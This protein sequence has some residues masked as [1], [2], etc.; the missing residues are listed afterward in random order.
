[1]QAHPVSNFLSHSAS[2]CDAVLR[3]RGQALADELGRIAR[4]VLNS[5]VGHYVPADQQGGAGGAAASAL[6]Q[7]VRFEH[8]L[9]GRFI[10]AGRDSYSALDAQHLASLASLAGSVL[11]VHSLAQR[12][13]HAYVQ[14]EA[15]LQHQSQILDQMHESVLTMDLNGFIT[16]WNK[17]AE[18]L[19][20]YST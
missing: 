14:V 12:S 17:G 15:Q 4:E 7:E 16:S 13:T 6:V 10:V 2:L 8:Q 18:R 1:M 20:G 9:F 19:F 5:P 3:L 11:Q